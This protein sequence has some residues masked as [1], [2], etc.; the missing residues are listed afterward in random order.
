M[1]AAC[2]RA[3]YEMTTVTTL[4]LCVH[5]QGNLFICFAVI[6]WQTAQWGKFLSCTDVVLDTLRDLLKTLVP[7]FRLQPFF[8]KL[9]WCLDVLKLL[10][11]G[12]VSHWDVVVFSFQVGERLHYWQK[13]RDW[14]RKKLC[15][16]S[17]SE[18]ACR[19]Q[20]KGVSFIGHSDKLLL[21]KNP[22]EKSILCEWSTLPL[23]PSTY[24]PLYPVISISVWRVLF[25]LRPA[26]LLSPL[27]YGKGLHRS[28]P[29]TN[30]TQHFEW[31]P[32]ASYYGSTPS[33]LRRSSRLRWAGKAY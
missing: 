2:N 8:K 15:V 30:K 1:T 6:S 4:V 21:F 10:Y 23:H 33:S 24:P 17:L 12:H 29:P 5:F 7:G 32:C 18:Q 20:Y 22:K 3:P 31:G 14:R 9:S 26:P 27:C 25:A 13:A 16:S 11:Q 28:G 19:M